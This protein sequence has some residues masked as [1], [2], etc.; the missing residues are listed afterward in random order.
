MIVIDGSQGEGG[1][2]ILRSGL[3]L[4]AITGRPVRFERIRARRPKPG[5]ARQHLACVRAAAEVACAQVEGAE[6]G[7]RELTFLPQGIVGGDLHVSIG[8]AGA[9]SLVLQ[10][11]LPMLLR[12][13]RSA[14]V[15][16]EGGTHNGMAPPFDFLRDA[17][18]P[19]LHR[20]GA[21]VSVELAQA[22]FYPA[23]GGK[24]IAHIDPWTA[25][26]R[27]D[28]H[29]RG[30]FAGRS[31]VAVSA[32]LPAHVTQREAQALKHALHW[33]HTEVDEREIVAAGPGNIL[34]ATLCYAQITEVISAVGELRKAAE[35]VAQE[36]VKEVKR[37]LA[38]EAPVGE[39]LADQ[40]LLPLA[41]GAGGSFTTLPPSE[42]TRTNAAIVNAFL[43]E[44]AVR[45]EES[46]G[47]CRITVTAAS[48]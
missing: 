5:L 2:Q 21:N 7:S 10:T 28:L 43:G 11:V 34:V 41:I 47:G 16:I 35:K 4:S 3:A 27:L 13:D 12:A 31:A 8:S 45:L 19:L 38:S 18:C 25:P 36:V 44:G 37:Y 1:G 29:E 26:A 30:R 23:G 6:L 48:R 46:D 33:S 17:F 24:L 42:H 20:C 39:H 15:V 9:C 14:R 32:N 40:L 22:G